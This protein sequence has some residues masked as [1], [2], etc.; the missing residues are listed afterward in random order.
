MNAPT[1]A[2]DSVF[3]HT[4]ALGD[5]TR[6]DALRVA[7]K[8]LIAVKGTVTTAGSQAVLRLAT[9]A[10]D[11]AP[12]LAGLRAGEIAGTT[13]IVG[14]TNLHELAYG[15][16]GMNQYF[17]T[18]P[19]PLDPSRVP[20]GSSSGSASAIGFDRADAA[21]GT[22]TGGSIRIPA[23]CCGIVGLKTTWGR[24]DTTGVWPLAPTLDTVGPMASDVDRLV[25]L[26]DYLE[27]GFA[28]RV[29]STPAAAS[30]AVLATPSGYR[31]DPL[32]EEAVGAALRAAG[33]ATAALDASWWQPAV[34]HGLTALVGEAYRTLSWLLEHEE[35]IEP[36]VAARIKLG[37]KIGDAQLAAA[38]AYRELL[39]D[40]INRACTVAPLLVTPTL[41]ML[42]PQ[43]DDQ[44]NYAP[45][46][47][48]TRPAN[49]AGTP[50]IAVPIPLVDAP[51]SLAHLRASIQLMGPPNSE[52]LLVSTARRIEAAVR[53]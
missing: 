50:A 1:P 5:H 4:F 30:V 27:S 31:C 46:T 36:R 28:E 51:P 9:V 18:P 45:Y 8:D 14:K 37:A 34:D 2:R 52:E 40:H 15:G 24:I 38:H 43:I 39:V 16:D 44:A 17:G 19:N 26:M 11:D 7:V 10:T 42:P 23:A 48:Y 47:A 22:D 53:R 3:T 6:A 12:L 13:H 29:A 35:Y 20:G 32:I 41:P 49:M 21:I 25:Q 33:I